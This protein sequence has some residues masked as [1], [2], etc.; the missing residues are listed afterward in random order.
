MFVTAQAL[1]HKA[2]VTILSVREWD[3]LI[4]GGSVSGLAASSQ[5][6]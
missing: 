3:A 2:S 6:S 1:V 5:V 4:V